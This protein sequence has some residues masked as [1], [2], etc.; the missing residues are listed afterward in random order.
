M[1]SKEFL[2]PK[3]S[4]FNETTA[5][6]YTTNGKN[7]LKYDACYGTFTCSFQNI[8]DAELSYLHLD[9]IQGRRIYIGLTNGKLMVVNCISGSVID[10]IQFHSNEITSIIKLEDDRKRVFTASLDGRLCSL[11][12][13]NG[14]FHVHNSIESCFV[15]FGI[16]SMKLLPSINILALCSNGKT[17]GLW[18]ETS[19][20]KVCVMHEEQYIMGF[21][22]LGVSRD[23]VDL[24]QIRSLNLKADDLNRRNREHLITLAIALSDRIQIYTFDIHDLRGVSSCTLRYPVTMLSPSHHKKE[25]RNFGYGIL[26]KSQRKTRKCRMQGKNNKRRD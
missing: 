9:G 25:N 2:P 19:F 22:I 14:K 11:E 26:K 12:E 13:T 4:V 18:H 15:S 20:K 10:V 16:I 3:H 5:T 23:E 6:I 24:E 7:L 1:N 17:W 8:G 21:E